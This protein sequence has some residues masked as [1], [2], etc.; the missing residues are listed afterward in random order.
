MLLGFLAPNGLE[1]TKQ[2]VEPGE[3]VINPT[4]DDTEIHF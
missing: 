2:S 4:H 3:W 1:H